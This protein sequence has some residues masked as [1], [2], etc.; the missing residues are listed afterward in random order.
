V[1]ISGRSANVLNEECTYQLCP[2]TRWQI[3]GD[4]GILLDND[5]PPA[6]SFGVSAPGQGYIQVSGF[7][8]STLDDTQSIAAGTLTLH[9]WD[10]TQP[11]SSFSLAVALDTVMTNVTVQAAIAVNAGDLIQIDDEVMIV[12]ATSSASAT[13][14]VTRASYGTTAVA[15][16][17]GVAVYQLE[18]KT[19]VM[20]FARQFFGSPASG[21][22]SYSAYFPDARIATAELFMTNSL[23]NSPVTR[24]QYAS[25]S[26]GLRTLSGGQLSIQIEGVLAIQTNAAPPLTV[27]ETHSV[28]DVFANIGTAPSGSPIQLAVTQNGSTYCGLTIAVGSTI[29]NVV[30]GF[31]L[32]PLQA[33]DLIG[34]DI[35]SLTQTSANAPGSNLTVTIRL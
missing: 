27:T 12:S 4:G 21:D 30:D 3:Q 19:F 14:Q 31:A 9:Y 13:F 18:K 7:S 25:A 8:F 2:L 32:G 16:A 28:W 10:E 24:M 35:V 20:P 22:Y 26:G 11:P 15:H 5:V 29:S 23:G 1:Q 6:P 33:L 17:I 34:L